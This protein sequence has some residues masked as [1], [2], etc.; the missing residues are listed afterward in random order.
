MRQ[1]VPR[2]GKRD[3]NAGAPVLV[4]R[5]DLEHACVSF[6]DFLRDGE[7]EA[8]AFARRSRD[9]VEAFAHTAAL[10]RRNAGPGVFDAQVGKLA[11]AAGVHGHRS[12]G[13]RV[14]QRV[15]DQVVDE[16]RQQQRV[17]AN[18]RATRARSRGRSCA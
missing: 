10:G 17:A 6:H 18:R 1:P 7:S 15:V 5:I 14:A 16:L 2:A 11:V 13:R 3:A 8:R 9:P 12:A 4:A